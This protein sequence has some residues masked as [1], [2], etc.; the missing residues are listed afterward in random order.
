M[1]ENFLTKEK[2]KKIINISGKVKGE[3][4]L[5]DLVYVRREKGDD[6]VR[7]LEN[8]MK[9]LG[10][11]IDYKEIQST[12]WHPIG[13]RVV[14]LLAIKEIFDWDD[15]KI[16]EM[17]NFAPR[18]SFI[19]KLMIKHFTS[20]EHTIKIISFLWSRHYNIGKLTIVKHDE[21]EKELIVSLEE[22][23]IHPILCV[24]LKGYFLRIAQL[25]LKHK[26]VFIK[27]TKCMFQADS[28]HE[29]TINW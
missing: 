28:C 17:G 9:E 23:K 15:E 10:N 19:V 5:T 29:Y 27:E 3:V 14:S 13:L 22:M 26:N 12:Q 21:K 16:F 11:P 18:F 25:S 20:L 7:S 1:S 6:G 2:I 4:F 8:K 24:Y